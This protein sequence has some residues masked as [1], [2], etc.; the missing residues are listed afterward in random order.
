[1]NFYMF[2]RRFSVLYF[3]T[4]INK[5]YIISVVTKIY[6]TTYSTVLVHEKLE[7]DI[8]DLAKHFF[9]LKKIQ[10]DK[11]IILKHYL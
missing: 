1:M 5:V 8:K 3:L 7:K 9:L 11:I 10:C 6:Y 4:Q 2:Y